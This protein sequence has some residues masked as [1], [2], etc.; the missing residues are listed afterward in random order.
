MAIFSVPCVARM[1]S[2]SSIFR[3]RLNCRIDGMVA[4]PTP[5]VPI[6]SD[7]T[8]SML[9]RPRVWTAS[10]AAVIQPAE[11][12]PTITTFRTL[13]CISGIPSAWRAGGEFAQAPNILDVRR[14]GRGQAAHL[15]PE[16]RRVA[17]AE[18][19]EVQ[20][21]RLFERIGL[22]ARAH[23]QPGPVGLLERFEIEQ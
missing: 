5:T 21:D 7:S 19:F 22:A 16:R 20:Y 11:P 13:L 23:Q 1:N 18:L 12:P 10:A 4:S 3:P 15:R 8:R 9:K 6:S 2:A 14:H 17:A